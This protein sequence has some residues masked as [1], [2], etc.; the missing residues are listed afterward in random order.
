MS[1]EPQTDDSSTASTTTTATTTQT[2]ITSDALVEDVLRVIEGN[3]K[4]A[5]FAYRKEPFYAKRLQT[6]VK[7]RFGWDVDTGT[8][9]KAVDELGHDTVKRCA[10]P[11]YE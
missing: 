4:L 7:D 11:H 6:A 5:S 8:I 9:E 2:V 3:R 10:R 1:I